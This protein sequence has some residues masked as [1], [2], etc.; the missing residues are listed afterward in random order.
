MAFKLTKTRKVNWPVT[1]E[2][3]IDGGRVSPQLCHAEFEILEHEEYK[4][5][6]DDDI[7]FLCRVVVGFGNDIQDEAGEPLSCSQENKLSL[8]KSAGFVR[9]GFL[10]AY[11]EAAAGIASKNAKGSQGTGPAVRKSRKTKSKS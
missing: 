4:A 1:I 9:V 6:M 3:P 10:N 7:A 5:L 8:I 11:H 2:V